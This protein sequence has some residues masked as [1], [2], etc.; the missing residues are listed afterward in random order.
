MVVIKLSYQPYSTPTV[1]R[2]YLASHEPETLVGEADIS[3][4]TYGDRR[5]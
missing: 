4:E 2:A 5:L 1:T 3:T